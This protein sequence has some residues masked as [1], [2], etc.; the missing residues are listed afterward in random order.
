MV[1]FVF[2]LYISTQSYIIHVYI[3]EN[4]AYICYTV[5]TYFHISFL[6]DSSMLCLALVHLLLLLHSVSLYIY[7]TIYHSIIDEHWIIALNYCLFEE[8]F[9]EHSYS[10][11]SLIYCV[12]VFSGTRRKVAKAQGMCRFNITRQFSKVVILFHTFLVS[13]SSSCSTYFPT[14]VIIIL[15][16]FIV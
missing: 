4:I 10:F 6:Y 5:Y 2:Q 1:L 9:C 13:E 12:Y 11:V 8:N 3:T 16:I 14:V 15:L 7:P